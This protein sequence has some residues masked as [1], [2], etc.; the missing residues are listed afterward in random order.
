[1]NR[2]L[3]FFLFACLGAGCFLQPPIQRS[4]SAPKSPPAPLVF[5]NN[6]IVV[7]DNRKEFLMAMTEHINKQLRPMDAWVDTLSITSPH[8]EPSIADIGHIGAQTEQGY[9]LRINTSHITAATHLQIVSTMAHESGHMV[10]DLNDGTASHPDY[11]SITSRHYIAMNLTEIRYFKD[12]NFVH[13]GSGHPQDNPGEL[14]A[15][16]Y[17]LASLVK[18]GLIKPDEVHPV[19]KGKAFWRWVRTLPLLDLGLPGERACWDPKPHAVVFAK[20]K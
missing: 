20:K 18:N 7:I 3:R 8:E 15:S 9:M 12:D 17:A 6:K 1:M 16:T 14:F 5:K 2:L 10:F 11:Q 4:V 19:G 13:D